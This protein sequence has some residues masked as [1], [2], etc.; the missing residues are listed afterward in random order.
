MK[1]YWLRTIIGVVV[2]FA[3]S[4]CLIM[5]KDFS[6]GLTDPDPRNNYDVKFYKL[7]LDV[8]DTSTYIRG[9]GSIL[10]EPAV[11]L[12]QQ[13]VLDF[14]NALTTDSVTVNGQKLTYIHETDV[15]NISLPYSFTG[16]STH[17]IEVY[18]HG[19]GKS[20]GDYSGIYNKYIS[21]WDKWIT[22][23]LS[24]PFH[25]KNWFPC[26]QVLTDKA[27]SV[28]VFLSTDDD[29]KAG[30]NGILTA[31]IPLPGN[32]I[33]YEWKSRHAIDYYLISFAVADYQDYSY[34][35]MTST[36]NDSILVQNY[37]YNNPAFLE[38]NRMAIDET[39]E[40]ILLYSDLFGM[41]P[42]QDEKYGHCTV[43]MGGGM[44]HQTMT[45]LS[46][47]S[48][49]LVAHELAHQWF[50]DYVTCSTWS[51][52][53]INEGFASYGE[54]LAYKYLKSQIMAD[55]WITGAHDYVKSVPG[56]S[57]YVP[58]DYIQDDDRI[59]DYRLTYKKGAAIIHMIRYQVGNDSLFFHTLT[60][61]LQK[62]SNSQAS[63]LD[64]R[65]HL[66]EVTG[67]D[68]HD[69]F[70]QWYF[71]EGFPVHSFSWNQQNDTLI[72]NSLQ[73][74]SS[75]T[76]LFTL[77]IEFKITVNNQDTLIKLNQTNNFNS[78]KIFLP[79]SVSSVV[80]DPNHWL[81]LEVTDVHH[82]GINEQETEFRVIPN[83]AKEQ[84]NI[85]YTGQADSFTIYLADSSGKI[86][87]SRQ[88]ATNYN[89]IDISHYSAGLYFIIIKD[90]NFIRQ[91]KFI[92]Y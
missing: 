6:T 86:L 52:I 71:G 82:T 72:I 41:Y 53:W 16:G 56:G 21:T 76:P 65:D 32:R 77:P 28:Y 31:Q 51:D 85:F 87:Y 68:F 75:S 1:K 78:W 49:L 61:F 39:A 14:S 88:S 90:L 37:I 60:T 79:G 58:E 63:G 57:V 89:H 23:T 22:W 92:V 26:K 15:L 48:F 38:Q 30:S 29:L 47:F 81:L 5:G 44:E 43:P 69:F 64:F 33:R 4:L 50:G 73:T 55:S 2:Q 40:L 74:T 27:D 45:T 66:E 80:V 3:V 54:Y 91:A 8:S 20:T 46:N 59:F 67:K 83:P 36:G 7:N 18:Y 17:S 13:V 24:E 35:V 84:V 19:L 9:F 42:Y 11:P 34:Y 12:L 62:Y 70:N 25:A 10:I